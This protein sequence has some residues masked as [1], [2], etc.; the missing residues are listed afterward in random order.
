[1]PEDHLQLPGHSTQIRS[2]A[3]ALNIIEILAKTKK[4]LALSEIARSLKLAKST[5]H[6]LI[7]TLRDFGYVEQSP[8]TGKYK[9]G[10]RLFEI[11]NIV[12]HGWDVRAVAG[13]YIQ[14]LVDELGETVHLVILDKGEVLYI[15]KRES[16]QS[17]RIVS[18]VG[19]R[20][21][22]HCTGVGK[23]LLAFLPAGEVK[24]IIADR[25]LPR[26]TRNTI[27]D[28]RKLED[29][30]ALVRELGYALD[31]E[32]I[33]DS[34]RCVAA[35]IRDHSGK[36]VAA[37]SVSGPVSRLAGE[38]FTQL[39]KLLVRTAAD[40]SAGL[41]YRPSLKP[42]ETGRQGVPIRRN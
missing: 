7:S 11:G 38:K 3:K 42:V 1:M 28:F 20:L 31:N 13:P 19:M 29:E 41:G 36:V 6:G 35:P 22:A 24:Q 34:L 14:C 25:G 17:L 23:V 12:A 4:E 18:Q 2:V 33:M 9:L 39:V 30:L 8:F 37:A 27:T 15:D 10:L 16:R 5:A 26:F 21:P 40:V 32:E